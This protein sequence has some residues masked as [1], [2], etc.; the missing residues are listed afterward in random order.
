MRFDVED[1]EESGFSGFIPVRDLT[2]D[3]RAVPA[4]RG[5]Y[6]VVR[7]TAELPIFLHLN[8]GSW[9]KG[10]DP[11]VPVSV[12]E[13]E[14][15]P[16]AKTLYVGSGANLRERIGLLVEFSRAGRSASVFHYGGRL[17]W[18]IANGQD[19][20]VAWRTAPIGIG[21]IERD[22]VI[23]FKEIYGEYPFANLRMPPVRQNG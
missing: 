20:L 13:K 12:L 21:S 14:W 11:T 9:F 2:S 18:Q 6:V 4:T 23:E 19:L 8:P 17:L 1:L 16:G 15:V 10:K 3:P 22:L 5:V 7:P